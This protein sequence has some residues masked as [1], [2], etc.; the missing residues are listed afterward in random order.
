MS[1]DVRKP[2]KISRVGNR[3]VSAKERRASKV[4]QKKSRR[5]VVDQ[6]ACKHEALLLNFY[7]HGPG[8]L[9]SSSSKSLRASRHSTTPRSLPPKVPQCTSRPLRRFS[10]SHTEY[11]KD[12]GASKGRR[13]PPPDSGFSSRAA[14]HAILN[15]K[16]DS[17]TAIEL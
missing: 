12:N 10:I 2:S 4:K 8:A 9:A 7:A 1:W 14:A 13:L 6:G 16:M 3:A 5:E 17:K 15:S 11:I